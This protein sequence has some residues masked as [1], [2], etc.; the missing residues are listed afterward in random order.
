[1]PPAAADGATSATSAAPVRDFNGFDVKEELR[2]LHARFLPILAAEEAERAAKWDSFIAEVA[3]LV[4]RWVK[5]CNDITCGEVTTGLL[6]LWR[7]WRR[8]MRWRVPT[9]VV[10]PPPRPR[11][12]QPGEDDAQLVQRAL[13]HLAASTSGRGSSSTGGDCNRDEAAAAATAAAAPLLQR[14]SSLVQAGLPMAKRG[15]FWRLFLGVDATHRQQPQAGSY[16]E[17]VQQVEELERRHGCGE[18]TSPGA[19]AARGCARAARRPVSTRRT[20][21]SRWR[22]R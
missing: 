7:Q 4:A 22:A 16:R 6:V 21:P 12:R 9:S 2:E 10:H 19:A 20:S 14:L 17:L 5:T 13:S 3:D 8:W 1:M 11:C 18:H 15:D